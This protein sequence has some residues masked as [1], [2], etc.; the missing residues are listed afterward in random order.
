MLEVEGKQGTPKEI[1]MASTK[2][3]KDELKEMLQA[4]IKQSLRVRDARATQASLREI[5]ELRLALE[6]RG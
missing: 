2:L 5:S 3:T 1:E 6:R 4:E